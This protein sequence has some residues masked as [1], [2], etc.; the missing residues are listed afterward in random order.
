MD[1]YLHLDLFDSSY[2]HSNLDNKN[3]N[4]LYQN[5]EKRLDYKNSVQYKL[6]SFSKK[7]FKIN[8]KI[9]V[10]HRAGSI[11]EFMNSNICHYWRNCNTYKKIVDFKPNY[12]I[13]SDPLPKYSW[14]DNIEGKNLKKYVVENEMSL[15]KIIKSKSYLDYKLLV[16]KSK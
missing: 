4:F 2:E 6:Y 1:Q 11:P 5:L 15:F 14:S 7:N 10:D 3:Y 12:V 9:A 16:Y 8:D 13:F